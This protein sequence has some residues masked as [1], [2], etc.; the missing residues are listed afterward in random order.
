MESAW[1]FKAM[2]ETVG[3]IST[4]ELQE[5]AANGSIVGDTLVRKGEDGKWVLASEIKGLI[6]AV[7]Y[8]PIEPTKREYTSAP[9]PVPTSQAEQQSEGRSSVQLR[10][11]PDCDRMVSKRA[12]QCPG[13]GCPMEVIKDHGAGP[14]VCVQCH[15]ASRV[16]GLYECEACNRKRK[17]ATRKTSEIRCPSCRSTQ[18]SANK[19]G[20]GLG[21]AVVGGLA[22]G[23]LGLIAGFAGS[24]KVIVTCLKCGN[25]WTPG[26]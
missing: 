3:P 13:C 11:C 26:G 6:Q 8:I 5:R 17:K 22:G 9:P 21:K 1:Y 16:P 14:G 7:P 2:G 20:F 19:K 23:P 24:N 25:T 15:V 18:V 10:P 4:A 12:T